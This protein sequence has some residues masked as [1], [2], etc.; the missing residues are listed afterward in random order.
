MSR[1]NI[2]SQLPGLPGGRVG[3]WVRSPWLI[4]LIALIIA[5]CWA[6]REQVNEA[7]A[8]PDSPIL[9][10]PA[11]TAWR[12]TWLQQDGPG[13]I[14][15]DGSHS[16]YS[17]DGMALLNFRPTTRGDEATF[18]VWLKGVAWVLRFTQSGDVARLIGIRDSQTATLPVVIGGSQ[19]FAERTAAEQ[20]RR[21]EA[22]SML[23][24]TDMGRFVKA[25][26]S[27]NVDRPPMPAQETPNP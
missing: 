13:M 8:E 9:V 4:F 25:D 27:A 18:R 26:E 6:G 5:A 23:L 2:F 16:I 3:G 10:R 7:P 11:S 19:S 1:P 24:P 12:G 21:A 22:R 17:P 15:F 14:R 20:R